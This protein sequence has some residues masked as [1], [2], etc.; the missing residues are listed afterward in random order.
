LTQTIQLGTDSWLI[1]SGR[2][3]CEIKSNKA[4]VISN[5]EERSYM[6]IAGIELQRY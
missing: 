6:G 3:A 5:Q 4:A 2:K 1:F